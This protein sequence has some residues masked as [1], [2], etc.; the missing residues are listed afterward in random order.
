[1]ATHAS[2]LAWR[3]PM[4]RGA[5]RVTVHGLAQSWTPPK[6]LSL[7]H[8]CLETGG[9]KYSVRPLLIVRYLI[10]RILDEQTE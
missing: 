8:N 5:W 6:R 2:S 10:L 4:D 3:I 1:M 7:K 9:M